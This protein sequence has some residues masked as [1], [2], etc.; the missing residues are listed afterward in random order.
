MDKAAI[1]E[2]MNQ[3]QN[4]VVSDRKVWLLVGINDR[5]TNNITIANIDSGARYICSADRINAVAGKVDTALLPW[6]A[7]AANNSDDEAVNAGLPISFTTSKGE[8]IKPGEAIRLST[9]ETAIYLGTN[10]H[11]AK[12]PLTIKMLSGR[13]AGR[14]LRCTVNHVLGHAA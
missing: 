11:A 13:K 14:H 3:G 9:G 4:L 8:A 5:P 7:G 2:A 1:K 6:S 10:P 12:Y